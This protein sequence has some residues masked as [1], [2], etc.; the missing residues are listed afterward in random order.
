MALQRKGEGGGKGGFSRVGKGGNAKAALYRQVH[1]AD[2]LCR[3][4]RLGGLIPIC[5]CVCYPPLL[6]PIRC[7]LYR[8][9]ALP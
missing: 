2:G 8:L 5:G 7:T 6:T 4:A 1:G 3:I 9:I